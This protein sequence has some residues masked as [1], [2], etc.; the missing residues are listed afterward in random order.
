[1][2][3]IVKISDIWH[4]VTKGVDG[5]IYFRTVVVNFRLFPVFRHRLLYWNKFV[6]KIT[7]EWHKL[8]SLFFLLN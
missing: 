2:N 1:M 4:T 5:L 3:N 8:G 6:N 7:E